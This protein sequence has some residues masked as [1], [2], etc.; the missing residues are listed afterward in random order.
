MCAK[1]VM[2]G[3]I[4][5]PFET[6]RSALFAVHSRNAKGI[7]TTSHAECVSGEDIE[8]A[9]MDGPLMCCKTL[10]PAC[11]FVVIVVMCWREGRAIPEVRI[12]RRHDCLTNY[13]GPVP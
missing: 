5:S 11:V 6:A 13:F 1:E 7:S 3:K 9:R 8:E 4:A 10:L 12:C 2:V